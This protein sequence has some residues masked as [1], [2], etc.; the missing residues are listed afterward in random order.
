[1]AQ[2]HRIRQLLVKQRT[3]QINALRGDLAELGIVCGQGGG[4]ASQLM[5]LVEDASDDPLPAKIRQQLQ[6][7]VELIRDLQRRP[8]EIDRELGELPARIRRRGGWRTSRGWA[9]HGH[10]PGRGDRRH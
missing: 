7:L 9:D 3:M 8:A 1:M 6:H 10:R 5:R 2:L 4:K